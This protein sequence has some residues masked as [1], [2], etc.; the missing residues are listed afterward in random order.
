LRGHSNSGGL[1]VIITSKVVLYTPAEGANKL[2]K[3][4]FSSTL[5][6]SVLGTL[7]KKIKRVDL[8]VTSVEQLS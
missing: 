5:S 3:E 8:Q 4:S 6:S 1:N 7:E 2:L